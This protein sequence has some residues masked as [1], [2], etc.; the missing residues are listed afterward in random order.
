MLPYK[1]YFASHKRYEMKHIFPLMRS[2][3]SIGCFTYFSKSFYYCYLYVILHLMRNYQCCFLLNSVHIIWFYMV[4]NFQSIC[5]SLWSNITIR[6]YRSGSVLTHVMA[7]CLKV[8]SHYPKQCWLI[9]SEVQWFHRRTI[10]QQLPKLLFCIMSLKI[11]LL[12]L[13]PHLPRAIKL[14][15]FNLPI[16]PH[17]AVV[18]SCLPGQWEILWLQTIISRRTYWC[19]KWRHSYVWLCIRYFALKL[20]FVVSSSLPGQ[21]GSYDHRP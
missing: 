20:L 4:M 14:H 12:K 19:I 15:Y 11:I 16:P 3:K 18:S 21:W 9:I 5:R 13:L 17:I 8:S 2:K 1:S 10:S 7:C 6:Q